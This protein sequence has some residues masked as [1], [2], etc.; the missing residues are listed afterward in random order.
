MEPQLLDIEVK[1]AIAEFT[2]MHD[3][4]DDIHESGDNDLMAIQFLGGGSFNI[5]F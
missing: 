4:H 2:Y 5:I 3:K 1:R